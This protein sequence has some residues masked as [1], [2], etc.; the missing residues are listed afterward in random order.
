LKGEI[1]N[2]FKCNR[3]YLSPF[4]WILSVLSCWDKKQQINLPKE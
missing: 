1:T 2:Y 3:Y 4:Q